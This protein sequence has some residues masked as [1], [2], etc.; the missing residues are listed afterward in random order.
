MD[1]VV[2]LHHLLT[3]SCVR[4]VSNEEEGM[5]DRSSSGTEEGSAAEGTGSTALLDRIVEEFGQLRQEAGELPGSPPVRQQ[6]APITTSGESVQQQCP[7]GGRSDVNGGKVDVMVSVPL[8]PV[9]PTV[10]Y[11]NVRPPPA[12]FRRRVDSYAAWAHELRSVQGPVG[13]PLYLKTG[14]N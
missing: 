11:P 4:R 7:S 2:C 12:I 1:D 10:E 6:S 9:F 8:S 14:L 13:F 3:T 5:I